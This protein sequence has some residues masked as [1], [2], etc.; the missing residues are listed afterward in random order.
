MPSMNSGAPP[1]GSRTK[2]KK[3]NQHYVPRF[4]LK[5]FSDSDK[6]TINL[7]NVKNQECRLG[8]SLKNQCYEPY[9]YDKEGGIEDVL[10]WLEDKASKIIRNII[11]TETLPDKITQEFGYLFRGSSSFLNLI[12]RFG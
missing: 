4:Y 9:F 3:K 8:A 7:F 1:M 2:P 11:L 12:F 10:G 5:N 6:R